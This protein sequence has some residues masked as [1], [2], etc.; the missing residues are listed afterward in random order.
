MSAPLQ[1]EILALIPARGG[2]KGL[3]KKNI[4]PLGGKP[5]ISYAISAAMSSALVTDTVV[6]SD[7]DQIIEVAKQSG[8]WVPFKRPDELATDVV[9]IFPVVIHCLNWLKEQAGYCPEIVVLLQ[10]NSPFVTSDIIDA[11]IRLLIESGADVVYTLSKLE[12]PPHW[13]QQ[14]DSGGVPR[15][16]LPSTAVPK[17]NRRQDM[18]PVYRPTGTVSAF[19][20]AYLRDCECRSVIP[21]FNLPI[22]NQ[23]TRA[24]V[25]DEIVALDIDTALDYALAESIL[26]NR[27][28]HE[29]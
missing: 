11:S 27:V 12:H 15:F 25:I 19:R 2:S 5:M 4:L 6:S 20:M 23:Q 1:G 16:L 13:A 8:A 7:S 22:E 28:R 21:G 29:A 9:G 3:P 17:G 24:I 18:P 26:A 10:A 14:L